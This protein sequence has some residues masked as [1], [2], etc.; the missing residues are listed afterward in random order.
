MIGKWQ[1]LPLN[2]DGETEF[3]KAGDIVFASLEYNNMHTEYLIQRYDNIKPGSDK[4]MKILEGVTYIRETETWAQVAERNLLIRL[5]INDHSNIN[6]GVDLSS[7]SAWVGQNYPNPFKGNTVIDYELPAV[8][9]V[10]FTV[11]DLTGREVLYNKQGV[12]PAGKHTYTLQTA[13]LEAGVY[14]YTLKAG[15]F[16]QT[17]QMVITE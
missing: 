16:T 1:T 2:K 11:M 9:E 8:A 4:S 14:F 3:L 10:S 5:N 12:M 15:S 17:R 7:S 6:D 13:N